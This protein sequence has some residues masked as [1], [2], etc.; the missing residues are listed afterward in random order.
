MLKTTNWKN[1]HGKN[2]STTF[3]LVKHCM[4]SPSEWWAILVVAQNGKST[5]NKWGG[6]SV[7]NTGQPAY[8]QNKWK[9]LGPYT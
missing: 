5:Q 8:I 1:F 9:A 4:G 2:N 3:K 7:R 6:F